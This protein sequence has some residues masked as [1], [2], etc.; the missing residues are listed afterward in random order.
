MRVEFRALGTVSTP[1]LLN[2][3]TGEFI[4]INI[5]MLAGDVLTINTGY[6]QKDVKLRRGGI[7]TDAFRFLD[8]DSIYIQLAPGDNIFRYDA[9]SN[10]ENLEVSIFHNNYFLGV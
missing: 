5:T 6:G 3:N 4:K 9:E 10:L 2:V 1:L 7:T 8:I